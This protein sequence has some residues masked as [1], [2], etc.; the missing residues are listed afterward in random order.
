MFLGSVETYTCVTFRM[1]L[2][3][4]ANLTLFVWTIMTA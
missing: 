4:L 2:I 1:C 3:F